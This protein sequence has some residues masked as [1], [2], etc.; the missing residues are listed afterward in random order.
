MRR[1]I[2]A[3][4][5]A[6]FSAAASAQQ[7]MTLPPNTVMGNVTGQTNPGSA[8]TMPQLAAALSAAGGSL[9]ALPSG[10]VWIGSVGNVATPQT[11]SGDCTLSLAGVVTCTKTN[12]VSFA[13]SATT[14]TTN[15]TN[16]SSGTLAAARMAAFGSGDVSFAA[17]GGAGTILANAVTNAKMATMA[18]NTVKANATGISAVPTDVTA[19]T[20]RSA[21]L[22]NVDSFT[23]HGDSIYTI[24]AT[25]RTVGTNAA[26]TASRT[27]TL[28][29]ANAV[30]PGQEIIVAD[31]QGTVT[32]TNTLVI[33]RAG[34]D[35]INGGTSVTISVANSGYQL[36]SDGIS[37]WTAQA[38]G[39]AGSGTV[40]SVTCGTGLTGGAITTTGTCAVDYATKSDQQTGTSA[41]KEINPLHQ[42]DHDSAAKVW[43][44]LNLTTTPLASYNV[45]SVT[46]TGGSG[47]FVINFTTAFAATTYTCTA[48]PTGGGVMVLTFVTTKAVGSVTVF[49]LNTS[50][51]GTDP[52]TGIDLACFG[53]Q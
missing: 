35:T 52:T 48:T 43:A 49:T 47:I 37:K 26:F 15:A 18:A 40:T 46:H 24:L 29:A 4:I 36:R 11:A 23:G 53:R 31:F 10:T 33:S 50:A 30:N 42:Q 7:Y 21:S 12:N 16:I 39:G 6:A 22:L 8:V 13:A 9:P 38:I 17:A 28:P 32:G 2:L 45:A 51:V 1:S 19:A 20:A 14:D 44:S 25:D 3:L 34:A 27:W 41:V 5:F